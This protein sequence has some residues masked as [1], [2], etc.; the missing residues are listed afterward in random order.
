MPLR[1]FVGGGGYDF[2]NLVVKDAVTAM[3]IRGPVAQRIHGV[4]DGTIIR[5]PVP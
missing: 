5:L 2:D 1:F 4:P 3:R